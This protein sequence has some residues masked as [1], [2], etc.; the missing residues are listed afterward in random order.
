LQP[1]Q[2]ASKPDSTFF[3]IDESLWPLAE[4]N[5]AEVQVVAITVH[6]SLPLRLLSL[7]TT[8]P[9][10]TTLCR[11]YIKNK[12]PTARGAACGWERGTFMVGLIELYKVA[13]VTDPVAAAEMLQFTKDWVR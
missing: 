10:T 13:A 11:Y 4:Y 5:C 6:V 2:Q 1:L 7:T 12:I 8:P 9:P 3:P